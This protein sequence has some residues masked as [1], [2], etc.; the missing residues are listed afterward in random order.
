LHVLAADD[1]ESTIW[2]LMQDETRLQK[3]SAD[4][5]ARIRHIVQI[6]DQALTHQG[7][8]SMRRW[9]ES[10]WL[11]LN[12]PAC[13]WDAGDVRDVQAFFDLIESLD[14]GNG[15]SL[16]ALE[17][18]MQKLYAAPD[19]Q[20]TEHLQ[21]MTIH[22]SKGLEF[23]TVILPGL[24]R[25]TAQ[26]DQPLLLWE[27]VSM[28]DET[29]GST[30]ELIAAPLMP[31]GA[32][33]H[34]LPTP[35]DYLQGLEKERAQNEG[36]RVL[37]V[38]ATR[39]ERKLHLVGIAKLDEN[40]EVKEPAANTSLSRLWPRVGTYFMQ[41]AAI[42]QTELLV[43]DTEKPDIASFT[44]QLMRIKQTGKPALFQASAGQLPASAQASSALDRQFA[45]SGKDT[46]NRENQHS[47]EKH[48]GTLAHRYVELI[49][50]SGLPAWSHDRLLSLKLAM[51]RW[52]EQQGHGV[53]EAEQGASKVVSALTTTL[54]SP[55]GRWVLQAR[56]SARAE[57]ALTSVRQASVHQGSAIG[58]IIDRTFI[59]DGTRWII[60]YKSALLNADTTQQAMNQF[61]EQYRSQLEAYAAL[62]AD[63]GLPIKKAI[64]F[65][66]IGKLAILD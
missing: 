1:H 64:L 18:G 28:P 6:L 26:Q 13:L 32:R 17:E 25:G 42:G 41:S 48:I 33:Q 44:P 47:I 34:D 49:A 66:S 39:A 45:Q 29:L 4:G 59:D 9:V 11:L 8:Q 36:L 52:L 56:D 62:F 19:A 24:D 43:E 37:Y 10:V 54:S 15:F 63:E 23:D 35:Y 27:E 12:G 22:K 30:T 57:F 3:M 65:L 55:E 7:R 60:D 31:K 16:T 61:A 38:A 46:E 20:A 40:N 50:Q 58:Q 21:F 2:S 53:K 14:A 51:Q 5:Q